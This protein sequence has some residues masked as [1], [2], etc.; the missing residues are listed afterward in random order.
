M[1]TIIK[2]DRNKILLAVLLLVGIILCVAG[3][4]GLAEKMLGLEDKPS[5]AATVTLSHP[6][7]DDEAG[8]MGP[9]E[10]QVVDQTIMNDVDNTTGSSYF[11]EARMSLEQARGKEMETLREVLASEADEE[12]RKTAQE[13]LMMLSSKISQEME[14]ENLI[15]AKG[16]QDAAVFLD[17]DTVTVILRPGKDMAIDTDNT[18]IAGLVSKTTGVPEEGVIV[19]TR[20]N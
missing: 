16:Y 4:S 18:T 5:T 1:I 3:F 19:I 10:A 9:G 12:V 7:S 11:V 20:A 13:R 17:S 14:L 8:D 2:L 15:R 6:E